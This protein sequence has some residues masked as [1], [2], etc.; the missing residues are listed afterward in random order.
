LASSM[1]PAFLICVMAFEILFL[2]LIRRRF[3]LERMQDTVEGMVRRIDT[4]R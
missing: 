1:Y 4:L 3:Y 2:Y